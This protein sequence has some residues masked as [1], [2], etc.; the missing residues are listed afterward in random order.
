MA[1]KWCLSDV[2]YSARPIK[3]GY[4]LGGDYVR[5]LGANRGEHDPYDLVTVAGTYEVTKFPKTVANLASLKRLPGVYQGKVK[6]RRIKP[7]R[8]AVRHGSKRRRAAYR[9]Q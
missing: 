7:K 6:R 3:P 2:F 8:F 4:H 5:H 9:A 1:N